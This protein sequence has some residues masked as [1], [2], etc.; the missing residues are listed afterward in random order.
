MI[1][2]SRG[3]ALRFGFLSILSRY[4]I[5]PGAQCTGFSDGISAPD[6]ASP[7]LEPFIGLQEAVMRRILE[8]SVCS[9]FSASWSRLVA[10]PTATL[11]PDSYGARH[12]CRFS[13]RMEQRVVVRIDVIERLD[14]EAA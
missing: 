5:L 7:F 3:P 10:N 4:L 13:F 8:R 1:G 12:S 9:S 2:L 6:E 14:A 11:A